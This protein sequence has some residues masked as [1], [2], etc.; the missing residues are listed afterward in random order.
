MVRSYRDRLSGPLL[1]RIDLRVEMP[2][3]SYA[4][5]SG[6]GGGETSAAARERVIEARRRQEARNPGAVANAALTL[7]DL[8]KV[9]PLPPAAARLLEAAVTKLGQTVTAKLGQTVTEQ[10]REP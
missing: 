7:A 2:E 3:V 4:E 1:D 9:A 5:L 8:R 6:T 10:S